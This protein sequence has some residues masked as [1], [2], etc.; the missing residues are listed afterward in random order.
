MTGDRL[1]STETKTTLVFMVLGLTAWYLAQE[2]LG[3]GLVELV[4]LFGVGIV[5]PTLINEA[6]RQSGE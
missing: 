5:V 1:L 4:A 3:N 2:Y 6:R